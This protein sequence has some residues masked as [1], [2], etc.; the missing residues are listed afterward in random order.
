MTDHEP[1]G[2]GTRAPEGS[3]RW[4]FGK[5]LRFF[6]VKAEL[7]QDQL[8]ELI[9]ISGKTIASYEK[10]WRVPTWETMQLIDAVAQL[11]TNDSLC[12]LWQLFESSMNYESQPGGFRDWW[13]RL[14][15]AKRIRWYEPLL[16]PGLLQTEDY[17]RAMGRTVFGATDEMV[18]E[19]VAGR[20]RQQEILRRAHPPAFWM[21]VEERVLL[22]P[23]GGP[24]VM[25]EQVQHLI[26]AA[27]QPNIV[28]EVIRS[29]VGGHMGL[30]G[31]GFAIA[32]FQD[33]PSL[34][35]QEGTVRGYQVRDQIDVE[36]M[37]LT[38]DTLRHE[39][40]PRASSLAAM[41]EAAKSWNSAV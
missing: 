38:W 5:M 26:E 30:P 34:G 25:A 28:I 9:H 33:E 6:R 40:E 19:W 2:E 18:E 21:I 3:P 23:V 35:Y 13:E 10:A 16:V 11:R 17:A 41:K 1:T 7:T 31:G 27:A 20:L 24:N 14:D 37:D 39:T 8:G 22:R 32:D 29:T 15:M 36:G 12:E 4:V